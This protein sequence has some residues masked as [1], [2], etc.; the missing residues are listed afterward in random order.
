[1]P[2]VLATAPLSPPAVIIEPT[3]LRMLLGHRVAVHLL[4]PPSG[5]VFLSGFDENVVRAIF[6]PVDRTVDVFGLHPGDTGVT[7]ASQDGLRAE[8][9]ISVQV[10][11]GKADASTSINIT[12]HPASSIFVAEMA[13]RAALRVAYP[14]VGA[15]VKIGFPD[16][17]TDLAPDQTAIVNVPLDITGPNYFAYHTTVAVRVTNFAQ[18]QAAPRFMLVSDFPETITEGGTLFYN[19]ITFD[20]PARLLYYHYA[21]PGAPL[22]RVL[23]KVANSGYDS[24]VLELISGIAGPDADILGVGHEATRRFLEHNV[25]GEGEVFEVPP[26]ATINVIDQLLPADNL[27]CGLMQ[28]RVISGPGLRVAVVVQ[29][30]TAS[31]TEPISPTLL[32]SAVK[33]SRGIYQIPEFFYEESYT[34]GAAPTLLSIGMLPLPN[35]VQGE[36]LGGDYGVLQ[37][38]E[39]NLLNPTS[40]PVD[41]GLWF[42]PRGGRATGTLFINGDLVQLHPVDPMKDALIRRFLVPARGFVHVTLVTMPEGGSA[43][44]VNLLFS[45]SPPPGAGWNL[46]TAVH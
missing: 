30:A 2:T 38:A 22:R 31:P 40:A 21:P 17:V 29:D 11:A 25:S 24:S 42:E 41:V 7:I 6:N 18:P 26:S 32:S 3:A 4:S 28:M 10:S 36:V 8:L 33:H 45:S 43:Y 19:D 5:I 1:M 44:P 20:K 12:G 15:D 13:S 34:V 35:L 9:I 39:V 16:D 37:S 46:S 27:V 23:V 14:L